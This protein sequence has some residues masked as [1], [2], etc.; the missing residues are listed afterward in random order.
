[1]STYRESIAVPTDLRVLCEKLLDRL[2]YSGAAMLEFKQ[3]Q[4]S[5][6]YVLMEINARLWGSLQ[7]AVDAGV[8]FPAALVAITLCERLPGSTPKVGVRTAWELGE[9]DHALALVRRSAAALHL[10]PETRSGWR[11]ALAALFNRRWSD[12]A[13]VFRLSDP[14]PF[15]AEANLW[16][17]SVAKAATPVATQ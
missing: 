1:V 5:G 2:D 9:V 3:D 10:P 11:A 6:E 7:L 12:H 14:M 4:Q 13:E 16:F 8:D 17:R 15:L